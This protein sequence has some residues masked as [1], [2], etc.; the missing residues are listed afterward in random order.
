MMGRALLLLAIALLA[1]VGPLT[2]Q[3]GGVGPNSYVSYVVVVNVD[4]LGGPLARYGFKSFYARVLVSL[5]PE[6][7]PVG[8]AYI[9]DSYPDILLTQYWRGYVEDTLDEAIAI[10]SSSMKRP[11]ASGGWVRDGSEHTI[12]FVASSGGGQVVYKCRAIGWRTPITGGQGLEGGYAEVYTDPGGRYP[13]YMESSFTTGWYRVS[14]EATAQYMY[15]M[16]SP[17]G[18]PIENGTLKEALGVS[19]VAMTVAALAAYARRP[20]T[21]IIPIREAY[22]P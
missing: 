8:T 13:L 12:V 10:V 21:P 3:A 18:R 2:A 15:G 20:K 1:A 22:W 6:G 11:P 4:V 19:A 17:C 5:D 16:E 14:L 7:Q 9:V